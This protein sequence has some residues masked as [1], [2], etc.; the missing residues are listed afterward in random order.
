[1]V[2]FNK[3][4]PFRLADLTGLTGVRFFFM[5]FIV[6]GE[7]LEESH[8]GTVMELLDE[9]NI[10]KDQVAVEVNL[11]IIKKDAYAT[12]KLQD[13]DRVEIVKFVGGG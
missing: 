1:M 4:Y 12:F 9:L 6:N 2:E 8:S 10:K 5:R 7:V 11:S 13:G 3:P